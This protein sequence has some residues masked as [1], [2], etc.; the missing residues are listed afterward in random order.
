[1]ARSARCV[2]A[3]EFCDAEI[4]AAW[5]CPGYTH[6]SICENVS[7]LRVSNAQLRQDATDFYFLT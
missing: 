7:D 5:Y 6:V 4:D 1:M 3:F 2:D